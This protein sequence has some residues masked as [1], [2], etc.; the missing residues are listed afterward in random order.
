MELK[1]VEVLDQVDGDVVKALE[2]LLESA[3][4]GDVKALAYVTV[5]K[6]GTVATHWV[7]VKDYAGY[8]HFLNSGAATL[9]SRLAN[10]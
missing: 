6:H 7:Q 4:K 5:A 2:D 10:A 8:Y 3:K 9:A 1:R